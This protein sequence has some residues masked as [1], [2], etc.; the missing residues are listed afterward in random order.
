MNQSLATNRLGC[1]SRD[2][3]YRTAVCGVILSALFVL[4]ACVSVR[5]EP[6]THETYPP[7]TSHEPVQWLETEP[8]SPHIKLARIIATSQSVDEDGLRDKILARAATL[9]ADA[10]VLGKSDVLESMGAETPYQSTM[11]PAASNGGWPFYYDRWSFLQG[12]TDRT[13]RTEYL[14]GTAIRYVRQK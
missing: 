8:G 11:G 12:S 4:V 6:L 14:S 1:S 5:V 10:V 13:G 7:Q 9:G 2:C 3:A